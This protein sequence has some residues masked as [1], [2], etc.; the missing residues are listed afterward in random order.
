MLLLKQYLAVT[1]P[2]EIMQY[3]WF[4]YLFVCGQNY[5]RILW[6]DFHEIIRVDNLG[7]MDKMI[8]VLPLMFICHLFHDFHEVNRMQN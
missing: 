5:T 3:G 2:K 4:V 7:D 8:T 6:T 1:G